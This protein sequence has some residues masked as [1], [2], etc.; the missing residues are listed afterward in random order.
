M[1]YPTLLLDLDHT[2][3][4]SKASEAAAFAITLRATGAACPDDYFATYD[5]INRALWA[6]LERGETTLADLRLRRFEQLVAESDLEADPAVMADT[7]AAALGANGELFPGARG[8]LD[9]LASRAS[10]ALITNGLSEV[11][12]AR[13]DRL[14]LSRYFRTIVISAEIGAAKPGLAI[15]EAAFKRLDWPA[16][17]DVLIVGDSL[18]SDIRGGA[19]YGIATCWYNATHRTAGPHVSFEIEKL[20]Q[21]PPIVYGET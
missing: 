5:R 20:E 6:G 14:R 7:Y 8:V 21:L 15:F 13:I 4:D 19:D 11:Q 1:R 9:E 16:K 18:S 17:G 10:L 12:R 2:L 3:F